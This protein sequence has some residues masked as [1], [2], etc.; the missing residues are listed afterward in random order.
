MQ[1]E[2][3][4]GLLKKKK[5]HTGPSWMR[6]GELQLAGPK[7]GKDRLGEL[8]MNADNMESCGTDLGEESLSLKV[9][10]KWIPLHL[11]LLNIMVRYLECREDLKQGG[12]NILGEQKWDL[13][14]E[15][16]L[17]HSNMVKKTP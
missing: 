17:L 4:Y 10:N 7:L 3:L 13:S 15:Q 6:P 5:P 11:I 1:M 12:N 14:H 16:D 9:F 8:E 2:N